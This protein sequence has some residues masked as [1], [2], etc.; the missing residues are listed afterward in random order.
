MGKSAKKIGRPNRVVYYLGF[1]A[2]R[3]WFRIFVGTRFRF[4][5]S[6]LSDLKSGPALIIAPH[7]SGIDLSSHHGCRIRFRSEG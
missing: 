6:G 1:G 4:D 3:L 2:V 7:I 5:R